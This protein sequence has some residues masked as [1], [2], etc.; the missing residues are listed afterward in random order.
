VEL[1]GATLS[2]DKVAAMTLAAVRNNE[3][4]VIAHD[5]ALEPL[6]R[7]F[8]RVERAILNRPS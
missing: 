2:P 5:D 1:M 4:Y 7:R 6:R 8:Q 3:L